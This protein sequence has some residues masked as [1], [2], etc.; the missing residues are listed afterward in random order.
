MSA[1]FEN[2]QAVAAYYR[3]KEAEFIALA[4]EATSDMERV[5][6]MDTAAVYAEVA[7]E[8]EQVAAGQQPVDRHGA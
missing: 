5:V 7:A 4:N 3:Q 1:P 2:A 6:A 8:A